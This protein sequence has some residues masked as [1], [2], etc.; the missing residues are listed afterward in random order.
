LNNQ[1]TYTFNA[2]GTYTWYCG[3]TDLSGR[4]D[5]AI[6]PSNTYEIK[7]L[8]STMTQSA[9]PPLQQLIGEP[10][11]FS[12]F[13]RNSTG[14]IIPTGDVDVFISNATWSTTL[15]TD[16]NN[17]TTYTFN[18]LGTYTWQCRGTDPSL[19]YEDANG[20]MET[21][22]IKILYC[23]IA[24]EST[25]DFKTVP[26][27]HYAHVVNQPATVAVKLTD[28]AGAPKNGINIT[29]TATGLPGS[30]S[31]TVSSLATGVATT[32]FALPT[33]ANKYD[34]LTVT[35][36]KCG[37]G[38]ETQTTLNS[39]INAYHDTPFQIAVTTPLTL[40]KSQ[41]ETF[42][43]AVEIQDRFGNICNSSYD[44][45]PYTV[46]S[47]G[48]D[49]TVYN[50]TGVDTTYNPKACTT[51]TFSYP[52]ATYCY[53][54]DSFIPSYEGKY[55]FKLAAY[56]WPTG[57]EYTKIE[58][59]IKE[60]SVTHGA[61]DTFA[62]LVVA[63]IGMVGPTVTVNYALPPPPTASSLKVTIKP[64]QIKVNDTFNI[65]VEALLD[66][67]TV[68]T[69]Y[70]KA[71]NLIRR[72]R[73]DVIPPIPFANIATITLV[74]GN[75]TYI[76]TKAESLLLFN[77]T[78]V[79]H[80]YAQNITDHL[81]G[82]ASLTVA[83]SGL[84]HIYII[85]DPPAVFRTL[86]FKATAVIKD[87]A[88]NTVTE[89]VGEVNITC[90]D[91]QIYPAHQNATLSTV[92][93]G[94]IT[95]S[96]LANATGTIQ[97]NMTA[98]D[99][100]K[101]LVVIQP[102]NVIVIE[103]AA[104]VD[105]VIP[106][107][108]AIVPPFDEVVGT[109][110]TPPVRPVMKNNYD[111]GNKLIGYD[112]ATGQ[113]TGNYSICLE[114]YH[115]GRMCFNNTDIQYDSAPVS[116]CVKEFVYNPEADQRISD[117]LHYNGTADLQE[118]FKDPEILWGWGYKALDGTL[119]TCSG[120]DRYDLKLTPGHLYTDY[121]N[122]T[123]TLPL[124][125]LEPY[126]ITN[127]T[128]LNPHELRGLEALMVV[129]Q[130]DG[131][132]LA[133]FDMKAP[134]T[135]LENYNGVGIA[136]VTPVVGSEP[137]AVAYDNLGHVFIALTKA[138]RVQVLALAKSNPPTVHFVREIETKSKSGEAF[139]PYGLDT[140]SWGNLYVLGN[141]NPD[142]VDNRICINKYNTTFDLVDSNDCCG[143]KDDTG[144]CTEKWEGTAMDIASTEDGASIF[145]VR[146][147][148][149]S[150]SWGVCSWTGYPFIHQ[151]NATNV[152]QN[153]SKISILGMDTG[154][155]LSTK[156]PDEWIVD[157]A[158]LN[159]AGNSEIL[160]PMVEN[161][162]YHYLRGIKYRRGY[163]FVLDYMAFPHRTD[164]WGC[165]PCPIWPFCCG[166]CIW[167]WINPNDCN[168]C[169]WS[170]LYENQMTRLL[171]LDTVDPQNIGK[172]YRARITV[173]P[174]TTVTLWKANY[175][176]FG[177]LSAGLQVVSGTSY[178]TH[179]IDVDKNFNVY[180]ALKGKNNGIVR[181]NFQFTPDPT[182]NFSGGSYSFAAV[183]GWQPNT[184]NVFAMRNTGSWT[185]TP[186]VTSNVT[187]AEDV[188]AYPDPIKETMMAGVVCA[189]CSLEGA[190]EPAVCESEISKTNASEY[191]NINT[192]L[193]SGSISPG[194]SVV[195][196]TS[197]LT[198]VYKRNTLATNI[199]AFLRLDYDFTITKFANDPACGGGGS[200]P[201]P[202][203]NLHKQLNITRTSNNLE[204]LV[205]GGG[206]HF[207]LTRPNYPE[208][209]PSTP[210]TLPYLA[211]DYLTNRFFYKHF[212]LMDNVSQFMGPPATQ[213]W[214][215]NAS[216]RESFQTMQNMY[217][218]Y[219]YI[220][221]TPLGRQ[222]EGTIYNPQGSWSGVPLTWSGDPDAP[223]FLNPAVRPPGFPYGTIPLNNTIEWNYPFAYVFRPVVMEPN[224]LPFTPQDPPGPPAAP[225]YRYMAITN[226]STLQV[227]IKCET[228]ANV[229]VMYTATINN[230]SYTPLGDCVTVD[231]VSIA[232]AWEEASVFIKPEGLSP[233]N[234]ICFESL[235]GANSTVCSNTKAWFKNSIQPNTVV[236]QTDL[237]KEIES[238]TRYPLLGEPYASYPSSLIILPERLSGP[239]LLTVIGANA[240]RN[241][242]VAIE[243]DNSS[244]IE[245]TAD[246]S[247]RQL[248]NP[249]PIR[250]LST[251]TIYFHSDTNVS[252]VF[253][254]IDPTGATGIFHAGTVD[255][256]S[257][258]GWVPIAGVGTTHDYTNGFIHEIDS[259]ICNN[260]C[261]LEFAN[262][263]AGMNSLG[264][265]YLWTGWNVSGI[266]LEFV[267][268]YTGSDKNPAF[269]YQPPK[270][271]V[272][273]LPDDPM[274]RDF[275]LINSVT[276]RGYLGDQ[277]KVY[278]D[279]ELI[280]SIDNLIANSSGTA[281]HPSGPPCT[282]SFVCPKI[283]LSMFNESLLVT[284]TKTHTDGNITQVTVVG[285][286]T[287]YNLA[288]GSASLT[289]GYVSIGGPYSNIYIVEVTHAVK[290]ETLIFST[291]AS[292]NEVARIYIPSENYVTKSSIGTILPKPRR[293]KISSDNPTP[294]RSIGYIIRGTRGNTELVTENTSGTTTVSCPLTG[295]VPV[296]PDPLFTTGACKLQF[297]SIA[298]PQAVGVPFN[299]RITTNST[300]WVPPPL[301]PIENLT[302]PA[303]SAVEELNLCGGSGSNLLGSPNGIGACFTT[304]P[305]PPPGYWVLTGGWPV[306]DI[307][308][309]EWT[310]THNCGGSLSD[311]L[312]SPDSTG[313]CIQTYQ[314]GL[315]T[316]G[317]DAA[318]IIV[319]NVSGINVSKLNI[320]IK[321]NKCTCFPFGGDAQPL[322]LRISDNATCF[323]GSVY[324]D[325]YSMATYSTQFT[326]ISDTGFYEI[327]LIDLGAN[328]TNIH[329]IGI[330]TIGGCFGCAGA[331][332]QGYFVDAIGII[333]WTWVPPPLPT[334]PSF[335]GL[336]FSDPVDIDGFNVTAKSL[337][338]TTVNK[339]TIM[340]SDNPSCYSGDALAD[341]NPLIWP[342]TIDIPMTANG[343]WN[344]NVVMNPGVYKDVRCLGFKEVPDVNA[345]WS[346]DSVGVFIPIPQP[347]P[348]PPDCSLF[349]GNV[350]LSDSG[351]M[352][353]TSAG[354]FF[355]GVWSGNVIVPAA[356]ANDVITASNG[357]VSW[358][359]NP[360]A[361]SAVHGASS[362]S[363]I[364][365]EAFT[366]V[367]SI[368]IQGDENESFNVTTAPLNLDEPLTRGLAPEQIGIIQVVPNDFVLGFYQNRS[369][370]YIY[371]QHDSVILNIPD[372]N[373]L[374]LHDFQY[375]FYDRFNNTFIVPYTIWL[376]QPTAIVL[377]IQTVRDPDN[378]NLTQVYVTAQLLYQRYD[379]PDEKPNKP[380]G[381]DFSME[382]YV[383][384]SS[385]TS[386]G[387]GNQTD[388]AGCNPATLGVCP[389][390]PE[391]SNCSCPDWIDDPASPGDCIPNPSCHQYGKL[392]D[393]ATG[394]TYFLTNES[395]HINTTFKIYGFGR[396]LLFAV[397]WGTN[398]YAPSIQIQP[399]YAGGM[400]IAMGRFIV[401]EPLILITISLTILTI[402][403]KF[404]K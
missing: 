81:N 198:P 383:Q 42:D 353:P 34:G 226:V 317:G 37:G 80:I 213:E 378:L 150:C 259:V 72:P 292:G 324:N 379:R 19:R 18:A 366:H 275:M 144:E 380:V 109:S 101:N 114:S 284:S 59:F 233:A 384:N 348:P 319:V 313:S 75:A 8:P 84:D 244:K 181:Y 142:G 371:S 320:T 329:C 155:E 285:T 297:D 300:G 138:T 293:L 148:S 133:K 126:N 281:M 108:P 351:G 104:C 230:A 61:P 65:T 334:P 374:G 10:V 5:N 46:N 195:R 154:M 95:F 103:A 216:Y 96:Q 316:L 254:M 270:G 352:C 134:A 260:G 62:N 223:S 372:N 219:Q 13:Y 159:N 119:T 166:G 304:P 264:K 349:S 67:G 311:V 343:N 295:P 364:T 203:I 175:D 190:I 193:L 232:G 249:L 325:Y 331:C 152:T 89:F 122:L 222:W 111:V 238:P 318:N 330:E 404:N 310:T 55:N 271:D 77:V 369:G 28:A 127:E 398:D 43:I 386:Y 299:I 92:D 402:K 93:R 139:F 385:N 20:P 41:G 70:N 228:S 73:A 192:S 362:A 27:Q 156:N 358:Q 204:R 395:G 40:S 368:E 272:Q 11:T 110:A 212:A 250:N 9:S 44:G 224:P 210:N 29:I 327:N 356:V 214:M 252:F 390:L 191:S 161:D 66:N 396:R 35:A 49:Q 269:T 128:V 350:Y 179:G 355:N 183:N 258:E 168:G 121:F 129:D 339:L 91:P 240:S 45:T 116:V 167:P 97:C 256:T 125:A 25:P 130:K 33:I 71:V 218:G 251:Q 7:K 403:R 245:G 15:H 227:S 394:N 85:L 341:S 115:S 207:A 123:V 160:G 303:A 24:W 363:F 314:V 177:V 397:F 186:Y 359:S 361:V 375:R 388:P 257:D 137:Q 294:G 162:G 262:D 305:P 58:N 194:S 145:V 365:N 229:T 32:T 242:N 370:T 157:P 276:G 26:D 296:N 290:G 172:F 344:N 54:N 197:P 76:V 215:L 178:E 273:L 209:P 16:L 205:E 50:S 107:N 79:Y 217:Y 158:C 56:I 185:A 307:A 286:D 387:D 136:G 143:V 357:G 373:S 196:V 261:L 401:L 236:S 64:L 266:A 367:L 146:D 120:V 392:S 239:T 360:F 323:T 248:P 243:M 182:L 291:A 23:N 147:K 234:G 135:W 315:C 140:D 53:V 163:L 180:V 88:N 102:F 263:S 12:C 309:A 60:V 336:K 337:T 335:V 174:N 30:P 221:T 98:F 393:L 322:N 225:D 21:Y 17:Q 354:P 287:S 377:D 184:T 301:P 237:N 211:Y 326:P 321:T 117:H 57:H 279:P 278:T 268:G 1:T 389:I 86:P 36:P 153:I 74:A 241:R 274:N 246:L 118:T 99:P 100:V 68:D 340:L 199:T 255:Y 206:S 87:S 187:L 235:S 342:W 106:P 189:G 289:G 381:K 176:P 2:L 90:P 63:P 288:N 231:A 151:Y 220:S 267:T 39:Y 165:R 164:W 202:P 131:G 312:G 345:K 48:I 399:F 277:F 333:N 200:A 308:N 188:A 400:S 347:P 328:Y 105:Y 82:T 149:R 208:R 253:L 376:R 78:G 298:S 113:M 169:L 170:N 141:T 83:S 247:G 173:E 69:N 3:G 47:V 346:I 94:Q 391:E 52:S 132:G 332:R 280:I 282:P 201:S 38:I 302:Y 14:D 283:E 51:A 124:T 4:Y 112:P 22:K 6:G 265:L 338:A 382:L 306:T 31:Q 171:V